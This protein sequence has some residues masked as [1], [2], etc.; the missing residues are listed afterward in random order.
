MGIPVLLHSFLVNCSLYH[1]GFT[2]FNQVVK[3]V[4]KSEV[5]IETTVFNAELKCFINS[6]YLYNKQTVD[7]YCLHRGGITVCLY[8]QYAFIDS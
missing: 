2:S 8:E 3:T 5:D 1:G 6:S 4:Y 7:D